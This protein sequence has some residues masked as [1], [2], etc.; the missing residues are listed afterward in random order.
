M[1]A[2]KNYSG[3]Q[4]FSD[5]GFSLSGESEGRFHMQTVHRVCFH[6]EQRIPFLSFKSS[7]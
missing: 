6:T 7:S 3:F 2:C 1:T 5:V 4:Q